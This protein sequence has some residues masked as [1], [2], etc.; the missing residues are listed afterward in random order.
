M[1]FPK[2]TLIIKMKKLHIGCGMTAPHDFENYDASPTLR[3]EKLPIIGKMYTKNPTRFPE[4]ARYGNIVNGLNV[5]KNSFDFCYCA[6]VL[7]HLSKEE[8]YISVENIY[9]Y[10]KPGSGFRLIMPDLNQYARQY[11]D[12]YS[13][14]DDSSS[15]N[16]MNKSLL[17]VE[18]ERNR[19]IFGILKGGLSNS[20]HLWLW[21]DIT[22]KKVLHEI[23]FDKIQRCEFNQST[24]DSSYFESVEDECSF[25][26]AFCLECV[27]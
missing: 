23:G 25:N 10:L 18:K 22:T 3:F 26:N 12:E 13:Q 17:G 2:K 4:N 24:L 15:I 16:F 1:L 27:K 9:K 11:L 21:D 8:F 14:G 6:H 19:S 20:K 7:E 5:E